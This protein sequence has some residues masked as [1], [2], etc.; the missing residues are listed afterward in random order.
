MLFAV[1]LFNGLW[2]GAGWSFIFFGM[3]HFVLIATGNLL[4]PAVVGF[5]EKHRINRR[6]PLYRAF[7]IIRTFLLVSIGEMFFRALSLKHGLQM[8]VQMFRCASLQ[9]FVDG[10]A[11]KIKMD[12]PDYL[13]AAVVLAGVFTVSLLRERGYNVRDH[14]M[15]KN[16]VTRSVITALLISFIILFGAYGTGYVPVDP[17]YANF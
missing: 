10:T 9:S 17:I 1:W 6:K 3:Y 11:L 2:H 7:Q 4:Q 16:M 8:F 15:D 5:C 14:L 12:L 13:I